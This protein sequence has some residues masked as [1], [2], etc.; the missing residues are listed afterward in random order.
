MNKIQSVSHKM[1]VLFETL[2]ILVPLST[3]CY[4]A[5]YEF[6]SEI[7]ITWFISDLPDELFTINYTSKFFAAIITLIPASIIMYGVF[8]LKKLF[9]NYAKNNIF[10]RENVLIYRK[11]CNTL[12][13]LA[14][15]NILTLPFLSLALTFQNPPGSRFISFTFGTSEIITLLI[16]FILLT[17]SYVMKKGH[18]L[19]SDNTVVL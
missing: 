17:I 10:T 14:M 9:S 19:E 4:W 3:I 7:G 5:F 8:N 11:L 16:G 6:L 15:G 13:A 12:F 2:L 1:Q 18:E